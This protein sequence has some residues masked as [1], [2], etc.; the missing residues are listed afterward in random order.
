[1]AAEY[2]RK[3][4]ELRDRASEAE[5][6]FIIAN[7]HF[8]VTG[9]MEKAEQNCELWIQAYPR[10]EVPHTF[11]SGIIFP[12]IGQYEKA[13]KEGTAAI[14][15]NP[16]FPISYGILMFSQIALNRLDES[17][18]TYGQT[19]ERKLDSTSFVRIPAYLMAFLQNDAAAMAQHVEWSA[20][21]P[22]AEDELLA[23]EADTAAY[24]GRL[25]NARELSRRAID[26]AE[27]SGEK[28]VAALYSALSGLREALF[29]NV[30]EARRRATPPMARSARHDVQ[31]GSALALACSADGR[32]AQA[33]TEDLAK[34]FPEDT[35]V[36]FNYLP[37]LRAK[38]ALNKGDATEAL[39]KIRAAIP[40]ELGQTT[41]ST[42]GWTGLYPVFVHGDAYLAARQGSE[43]VAEFRK[44]LDHRGIVANGPIGP[45]AHLGL[46]RAYFLQG[47][48]AKARAAYQNFLA[49]WKDADS[50]IPILKQAKREYAKLL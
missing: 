20:A 23:L 4:Y 10:A 24:A 17:K 49:L 5:K 47:D 50:D 21:R 13:A 15:L 2:A 22:G 38:L 14:Q 30:E 9:D 7:F 34:T 12:V 25:R 1:M 40:Y 29:G 19:L 26:S 18:V 11:L 48:T 31:Y 6:Y 3:A 16:D 43:A 45:L 33:L 46:A 8:T 44:I 41:A 37:T 36:Q 39:E 42:Y 28:E 32:S 27:R 35:I